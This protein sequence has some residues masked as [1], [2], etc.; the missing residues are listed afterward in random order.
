MTVP[1]QR[2]SEKCD[3]NV[4]LRRLITARLNGA[5]K[6]VLEH[7]HEDGSCP[8][9][10][11][12]SVDYYAVRN[13]EDLFVAEINLDLIEQSWKEAITKGIKDTPQKTES[14]SLPLSEI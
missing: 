3:K 11:S 1:K 14:N 2:Q 6:Y 12:S 9:E 13:D 8:P 5:G 10:R 7:V 4:R